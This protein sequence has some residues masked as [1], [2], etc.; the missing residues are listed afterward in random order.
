MMV[1]MDGAIPMRLG[2]LLDALA[3]LPR[4]MTVYV[5]TGDALARLVD[6]E[7]NLDGD[8]WGGPHV[9]LFVEGY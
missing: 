1:K 3:E 4:D 8:E 9:T 7:V 2:E 5:D 6:Y